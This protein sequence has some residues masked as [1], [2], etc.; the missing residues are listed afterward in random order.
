MSRSCGALTMRLNENSLPRR[1]L[2]DFFKINHWLLKKC[3]FPGTNLSAAKLLPNNFHQR[4]LASASVEF[5]IE[6][7]FPRTEI[8][9]AFCDG[10]DHFASHDLAFEMSIGVVFACAVVLVL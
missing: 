6:D 5:A 3:Q 1:L 8:Q 7:L 10:H 9:F 2:P 4:T